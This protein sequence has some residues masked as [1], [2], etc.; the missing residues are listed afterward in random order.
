MWEPYPLA[1][2]IWSYARIV[3][4]K[5]GRSFHPG[6]VLL[7]AFKN[8]L[9]PVLKSHNWQKAGRVGK[10]NAR[11]LSNFVWAFSVLEYNPG[12]DFMALYCSV[13]ENKLSSFSSSNLVPFH[14]WSSLSHEYI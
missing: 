14:F 12:D 11:H 4:Y 7:D 2:L 3:D 13:V 9:I 6:N 10:D 5:I 1:K 8:A